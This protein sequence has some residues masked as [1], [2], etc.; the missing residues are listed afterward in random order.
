MIALTHMRTPND[1]RLAEQ[2]AGLDLILGGHDHVYEKHKVGLWIDCRYCSILL[3]F[4]N[5]ISRQVNGKYILKSGTDFRQFSKV[6]LDFSGPQL[7]VEIEAVEVTSAY[8]PDPALA[9]ELEQVTNHSPA[10]GH[11][12]QCSPPIG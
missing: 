6:T 8:S 2:V 4:T 12:T 10:C 11:V 3:Y 7:Q 5:T 9:A 1:I